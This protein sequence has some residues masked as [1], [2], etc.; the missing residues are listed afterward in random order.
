M[1]SVAGLCYLG[2]CTITD[3]RKRK[4]YVWPTVIGFGAA[5]LWLFIVSHEF[6]NMLWATIVVMLLGG[7]AY[8]TREAIGVGDVWMFGVVFLLVG[9]EKGIFIMLTS[10]F[11]ACVVGSI[12]YLRKKINRIPMAPF[13]LAVYLWQVFL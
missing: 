2:I 10:L 7:I 9:G 13:I 4:I 1:G 6:E 11:L 3:I 5:V 8:L 12:L